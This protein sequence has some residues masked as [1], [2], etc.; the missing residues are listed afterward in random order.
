M[1]PLDSLI[2]PCLDSQLGYTTGE[3]QALQLIAHV[4]FGAVDQSFA[5]CMLVHFLEI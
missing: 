5:S 4:V 2:I 1:L 3:F